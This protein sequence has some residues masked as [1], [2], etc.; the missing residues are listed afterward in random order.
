MS[1]DG[2]TNE[3][4]FTNENLGFYLNELAKEYKKLV[5]KNMPAEI[6]LIG[7]AA[8]V[9]CY[10]FRSM[11][12]DIDAVILAASAVRD[13]IGRVGD[14]YN[15]P[16]GWINTDFEKTT[17]YSQ[18]L[19]QHS[20]Y[21]RT[22]AQVLSVRV[23]KAEY[24]VAMKLKSYRYYKNDISDI[25]GILAAHESA[26]DRI[27]MERIN[28]AVI[29]LYGSWDE[30]SP[31]S[32]QFIENAIGRSDYKELLEETRQ[33]EWDAREKLLDFE[34]KYPNA[35]SEDNVDFV[36][37]QLKKKAMRSGDNLGQQ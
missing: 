11:T 1:A 14:R 13:A 24:L 12:T 17:S 32:R 28:K 25:V 2:L 15:L 22:F 36:L 18:N 21:Y 37:L 5:G 33:G 16:G 10:D 6:I 7:G 29:D 20:T 27:T 35:L 30:F 9:S 23:V 34:V 19:M 3:F 31:A 4:T 8:I 26:G